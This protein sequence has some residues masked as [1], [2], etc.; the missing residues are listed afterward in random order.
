MSTGKQVVLFGLSDLKVVISAIKSA[1]A[2]SF[3][4]TTPLE[5]CHFGQETAVTTSVRVTT[6]RLDKRGN[7][8]RHGESI[9]KEIT[10]E[11]NFR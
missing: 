10:E 11:R 7:N 4:N 8:T 2:D 9:N 6:E 5:V 3:R 1:M